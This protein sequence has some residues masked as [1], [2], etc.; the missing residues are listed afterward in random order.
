MANEHQ[1]ERIKPKTFDCKDCGDHQR[2]W[3]RTILDSI[4]QTKAFQ[5]YEHSTAGDWRSK[6]LFLWPRISRLQWRNNEIKN[7][8]QIMLSHRLQRCTADLNGTDCV[9]HSKPE[10][11][12]TQYIPQYSNQ[13][14]N[15]DIPGPVY[16]S[17]CRNQS[18]LRTLFLGK[19]AQYLRVKLLTVSCR[20]QVNKKETKR[21][22]CQCATPPITKGIIL[23]TMRIWDWNSIQNLCEPLGFLIDKRNYS[24]CPLSDFVSGFPVKEGVFSLRNC[25]SWKYGIA[26][27]IWQV[28]WVW[29]QCGGL[30]SQAA[31]GYLQDR[32]GGNCCTSSF[33]LLVSTVLR[34]WDVRI[35]GIFVLNFTKI[36]TMLF[37]LLVPIHYDAHKTGQNYLYLKMWNDL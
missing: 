25:R 3:D 27:F 34:K 22:A 1:L 28:F 23:T 13:N 35:T 11:L 4:L 33:Q 17:T 14:P 6:T 9:V 8:A 37:V 26:C 20:H 5:L 32:C 19:V 12:G 15:L 18:K 2:R 7:F 31:I 30:T 10:A 24:V 16:I 29:F 36:M 21:A